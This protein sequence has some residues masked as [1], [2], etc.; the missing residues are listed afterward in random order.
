M[1]GVPAEMVTYPRERHG[2]HERAHQEDVLARLLA[3]YD[4]YLKQ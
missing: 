1:L 4:K 3:W 2:F